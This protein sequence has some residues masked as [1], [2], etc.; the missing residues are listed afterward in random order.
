MKKATMALLRGALFLVQKFYRG[1]FVILVV[2]AVLLA[3]RFNL[4][5]M[6]VTYIDQNT[7]YVSLVDC[8]GEAYGIFADELEVGQEI[9]AF[10][11]GTHKATEIVDYTEIEGM[12]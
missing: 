6:C 5:K 10:C 7:G 4:R 9:L 3:P 1:I 2:S 12:N 11:K 8:E